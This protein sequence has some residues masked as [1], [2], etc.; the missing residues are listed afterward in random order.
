MYSLGLLE[1][2]VDTANKKYMAKIIIIHV[3]Y[4]KVKKYT[5]CIL[6]DILSKWSGNVCKYLEYFGGNLLNKY[7]Q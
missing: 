1:Y 4:M 6:S 2:F 5:L 3:L 7:T